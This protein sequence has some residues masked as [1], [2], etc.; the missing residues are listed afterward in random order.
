[1]L[2]G[3]PA[4]PEGHGQWGANWP[5]QRAEKVTHTWGISKF[6]IRQAW[7]GYRGQWKE[8]ARHRA[9]LQNLRAN[10][11]EKI[12]LSRKRH[13]PPVIADSIN[14]ETEGHKN[15]HINLVAIKA[16]DRW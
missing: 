7:K 2:V 6:I 13:W 11:I 16:D 1:M 4:T 12:Y 5:R 9:A 15:A 3:F 10:D 14:Y 8:K